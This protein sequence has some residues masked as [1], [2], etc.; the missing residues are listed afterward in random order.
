MSSSGSIRINREEAF[1]ILW[2]EVAMKRDVISNE[3]LG[4][5]VSVIKGDDYEVVDPPLTIDKES[6]ESDT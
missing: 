2:Q 3:T 5:L 4:Q 6:N 1:A